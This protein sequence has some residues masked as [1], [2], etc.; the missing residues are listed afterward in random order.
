MA[1]LPFGLTPLR[2]AAGAALVVLLLVG[3]VLYYCRA[4]PGSLAAAAGPSA[5]SRAA[6]T[7][8]ATPDPPPSAATPAVATPGGSPSPE[9][10]A[11]EIYGDTATSA[12][13][14]ET[15]R[16]RGTYH[17]GADTFLQV[18]VRE[19]SRWTAY[20]VSPKTDRLGRFITYVELSERGPNWVRVVD[21]RAHVESKPFVLVI[22]G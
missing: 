9:I 7:P 12:K 15:V 6:P 5:H 18:E 22:R 3:A 2:R 8:V 1:P 16:I 13:P 10:A 11:I 20:P 21:P 17:R 4:L 14:F 19:G